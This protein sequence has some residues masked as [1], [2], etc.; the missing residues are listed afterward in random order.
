MQALSMYIY[1]YV[2]QP[3]ALCTY[4]RIVCETQFAWDRGQ[5]GHRLKSPSNRSI[6]NIC[7]VLANDSQWKNTFDKYVQTSIN[8]IQRTE[9]NYHK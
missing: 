1:I 3:V 2:S 9:K 6:I 7:D 5:L 8:T 4:G